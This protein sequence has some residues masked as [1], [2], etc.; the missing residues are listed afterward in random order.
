M[1]KPRLGFIGIGIMGTP[2]SRNL[3]RAGYTLTLYDINSLSANEVAKEFANVSVAETPRALAEVSDIVITMLPSGKPVQKVALGGNGLIEGFKPGALLL[4]TSSSEPQ[5]TIE[6]AKVLKEKNI[7][8]VD[9][10]VSGAQW[11]AQAAELVFMVGGEKEHVS[12][13]LPLLNVMGNR[14]FHLGPLGS[15]HVMKS[16]NNL[17]TAITFMATVEGLTIGKRY[18]LDTN[19][20][21]DVLNES[22]GMSWISR[23]QIKQRITSRK[24]DDPFKLEL[25][26][27]DINIA[28]ELAEEIGLEIP[29]SGTGRNL[30]GKAGLYAGKNS[31][32]SEVARW[33]EHRTDTML[34]E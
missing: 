1:I 13:V 26:I 30:W 7:D 14:V 32:I 16:I 18:G 25:M 22:T 21:T 12:R 19:V 10:P 5:L 11:G 27:K 33:I 3:A 31:S 9:A 34:S 17:V 23:T 15:G 8:L 24:F 2:M 29:L 20:M 28:L 6:T 4:D